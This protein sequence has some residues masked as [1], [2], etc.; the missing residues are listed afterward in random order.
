[1]KPG[2]G[3]FIVNHKPLISMVIKDQIDYKT[4]K[5]SVGLKPTVYSYNPQTHVLSHQMKVPLKSGG[6]FLTVEATDLNG[7]RRIYTM[8]F[9]IKHTGLVPLVK[10]SH[11]SGT[12]DK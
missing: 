4:I 6:H 12:D 7:Q 8:Y 3:Q 2:D 5:L 10:T 9:R 11:M 1:V